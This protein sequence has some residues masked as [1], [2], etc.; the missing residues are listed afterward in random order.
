M[1]KAK[2]ILHIFATFN[3]GGQQVRVCQLMRAWGTGIEHHIAA[4]DGNYGAEALLEGV[5]YTRVD[6]LPL[7][8]PGMVARLHALG[9]ALKY[10]EAD[11]VCTYNWGAMDAV[12]ANRLFG[13]RKLIHHED[14]FGPTEAVRQDSKRVLYRKLAL[15]GATKLVLCSNNL[16]GIATQIWRRPVNQCVMIPNGVALELFSTKPKPD[17]IPGLIK[18]PNEIIV[19]SV[20]KLRPEKNFARMVEAFAEASHGLDARLVIVGDGP[21]KDTI[22]KQITRLKLEDR[23]IL[24][25]FMAEPH[26]YMGLFD[27]FAMSSDTEQ[28]P[29]SLV[30]AMAASVAAIA[31]D[32]GDIKHIVPTIQQ[33]FVTETSDMKI[34]V[35]NLRQLITDARLRQNLAHSN[36]QAV[37]KY[38]EA[39]MVL[40]YSKLYN[41]A[42][43]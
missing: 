1:I 6:S 41:Q 33:P 18:G 35:N 9:A 22:M 2:R 4:H 3:V 14:G 16:L 26:K 40:A 25:G 34:Y 38:S 24:P 5:N 21:D 36:Y 17:A 37:Q 28:F 31:T 42:C 20:A 29:I 13:K 19:G 12:L 30:E 7:K 10:Y 39:E 43:G 11:L 27:V 32:V 15:P 23:V 8:R